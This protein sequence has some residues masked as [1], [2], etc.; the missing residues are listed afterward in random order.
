MK[1]HPGQYT[2]AEISDYMRQFQETGQMPATA[3]TDQDLA[4][5][6]KAKPANPSQDTSPK[7]TTRQEPARIGRDTYPI[8]SL[9]PRSRST[10]MLRNAGAPNPGPHIRLILSGEITTEQYQAVFGNDA[11]IN[12]RMGLPIQGPEEESGKLPHDPLEHD[13]NTGIVRLKD[14]VRRSGSPGWLPRMVDYLQYR[15]PTQDGQ[16][17]TDNHPR[18][19]DFLEPETAAK[20]VRLT[21]LWHTEAYMP[22]ETEVESMLEFLDITLTLRELT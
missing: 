15:E 8:H 7:E 11:L 3:E 12:H 18:P 17:A 10:E 5:L 13:R 2:A 6:L 16:P 14:A 4:D 21:R 1:N 9:I 19:T 22:D 20:L